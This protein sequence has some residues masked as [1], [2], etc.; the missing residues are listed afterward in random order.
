MYFGGETA[1]TFEYHN[2]EEKTK[3]AMTDQGYSSLGDVGYL[4]DDGFLYLTDRKSFMIISGGVN[5]YPKE[6]EDL[7][8]G[9]PFLSDK[10]SLLQK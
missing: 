7:L 6:T 4:D 10:Y 2:D 1:T 9:L 5:I 3:S 8:A